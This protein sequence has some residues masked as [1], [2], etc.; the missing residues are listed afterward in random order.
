M[1]PKAKMDDTHAG[2][3][4]PVC[5]DRCEQCGDKCSTKP[6]N[7]ST[8]KI[9]YCCDECFGYGTDRTYSPSQSE[10]SD[11]DEDDDVPSESDQPHSDDDDS[12]N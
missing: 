4:P 1:P 9:I 8:G 2:S 11:D 6:Y 5:R 12:D 3:K 10:S 7:A